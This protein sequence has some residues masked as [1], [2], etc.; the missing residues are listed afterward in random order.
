[1][2]LERE[3]KVLKVIQK[4]SKVIK[5]GWL[6]E[7][8]HINFPR[9][10]NKRN[11]KLLNSDKN[12]N[13]TKVNKTSHNIK[14]KNLNIIF[15]NLNIKNQK[16]NIKNSRNVLKI[17]DNRFLNSYVVIY[18]FS[19]TLLILSLGIIIPFYINE[20]KTEAAV[21]TASQSTIS[22]SLSSNNIALNL[23][24]P[25]TYDANNLESGIFGSVSTTAIVYTTNYTG[26]TLSIA[27]TNNNGSDNANNYSKLIDSS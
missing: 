3:L 27:A 23:L 9:Q 5:S 1:M 8:D 16:H 10:H 18:T 4:I 17:N 25:G 19:V 14:N 6:I 13:L 2:A 11:E 15:Q 20:T 21:G 12:N 7:S 24:R 22:L 26:Y